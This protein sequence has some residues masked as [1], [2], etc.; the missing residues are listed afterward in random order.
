MNTALLK[1]LTKHIL[2]ECDCHD[3]TCL[4]C[5]KGSRA[6]KALLLAHQYG[7]EAEECGLNFMEYKKSL[8]ELDEWCLKEMEKGES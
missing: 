4:R 2:G 3:G 7:L 6:F 1:A 8:A 5:R